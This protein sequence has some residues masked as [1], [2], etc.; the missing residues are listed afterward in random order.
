MRK[1]A[2]IDQTVSAGG[3]ERFLHGLIR[4][5]ISSGLIADWEV[6]LVRSRLNSARIELPWP[7]HL[8][9]PNLRLEYLG[10]DN[11]LSRFLDRLTRRGRV[12]GIR[13]SG[14]ALKTL[15]DV[16]RSVG[17]DSWRAYCGDTRLWIE[18]YLREN[19]FDVVYF[20][21]PF[22][23]DPPRTTT[24]IVAT[25]HDFI[26]KY[27]LFGTPALRRQIEAEVPRWFE[28]CSEL[29][30]STQFVADDLAKFYPE[31]AHKAQ[32]IRLG[33]P[34]AEREPTQLEID[35]FRESK[36]LP[37]NFA[38]IV[39]WIVEHKNHKVAFEAVAKLRDRGRRIPLVLVG[40]NS[41]LLADA[42]R[43]HKP[44]SSSYVGQIAQFCKDANLVHG[45]DY[46]SLGY[47]DDFGLDCLYR[48][49]TMLI[50]PTLVEAGSFPASEAMRVGCPVVFSSAPV[51][52]EA[53]DLV[54]GNAWI[55]PPHE[56]STL[57][58]LIADLT[59]N[60]E[61]TERRAKEAQALIPCVLSWDKAAK[62]Y[63]SVFSRVANRRGRIDKN[64]DA[65]AGLGRHQ[66]SVQK[67]RTGQELDE[68][69]QLV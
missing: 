42:A 44:P 18:K 47:V 46:F 67:E 53:I 41:H 62:G 38:L 13:G 6:V 1:L 34:T 37:E 63:F 27:G 3:V 48:C 25:P 2:I 61:E 39:G 10:G 50:V 54:N 40:P 21:Y 55:F 57:A 45:V 4:G 52:R 14:L 31:W 35:A 19:R 26:F 20:S 11:R 69:R 29:V 33:I 60:W 68:G 65:R 7:Q 59:D 12:L 49:A 5:A 51:Y 23:L 9:H 15:A 58:D 24:P 43:G 36:G 16:I 32:V 56:S 28:A 30:V 22:F 17:P 66:Q 8:Q 64:S